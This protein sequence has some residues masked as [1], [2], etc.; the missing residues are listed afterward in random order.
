MIT[1]GRIVDGTGNP[2]YS[3]DLGIIGGKIAKIGHLSLPDA[4]KNIDARGSMLAPG[5]VDIHNHSDST[6]LINPRA[7]SM[8]RQGVTTQV[9]GNCGLS[10]APV[11]DET[12][13]AL[14]KYV[15][16]FMPEV[17]I[18]WH[19]FGEYL[20][21]CGQRRVGTNVAFLVGHGSVRIA[22]LGWAN[23]F[24]TKLELE[25]MKGLVAEA[26]EAGAFGL[27]TGLAYA[28]GMFADTNEIVDLAKV[29]ARYGGFYATHIRTN[30]HTYEESVQEALEIGERSGA[31]VQV[32]H[33]ETHYPNWGKQETILKMLENARKRGLDVT[34]DVPPY[35]LGLT[36]LNTLLPDWALEGGPART[37]ERLKDPKIRQEIKRFVLKE[38]QKHGISVPTMIADE[39]SSKIWTETCQ[40]NPD[41]VGKDL[42]EISKIRGKD[43]L[44]CAL[45]LLMEEQG[46]PLNITYE[47]HSEDDLVTLVRSPLSMIESDA[48]CWAPYGDLSERAKPHPRTYG[49]FP[50]TFRKYVRGETR[51]EEP[52]EVGRKILTLE[53]AVRKMASFPARR[54]GLP[55]RGLIAEGMSADIVIFNPK[56]IEDQATYAKPNQYPKGVEYVLVNGQVVIE[57]GEHTG[58][59][60]GKVLRRPG[61]AAKP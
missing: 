36:L 8:V 4:S 42:A 26:M 53:E 19:T 51:P 31:P 56:T 6:L 59:L 20:S 25:E 5:F 11:R 48:L 30:G 58:N 1:N 44:E 54:L 15:F 18:D 16:G 17:T 45:D 13:D 9:I 57:K 40:K 55:D 3:A 34:C 52:K 60:S 47:G 10:L 2:W 22:I 41:L 14:K 12:V 46:Q 39:L 29:A 24:P 50:L 38:K 49:V 23:R 43:P 7:E 33:V 37:V 61:H 27:S 35:L 32:S 21:I 28:P